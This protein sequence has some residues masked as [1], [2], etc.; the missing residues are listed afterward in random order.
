VDPICHTLAGAAIGEA[1]LK[2]RTALGMT[3]L[4][5]AANAPDIDIAVLA[6]GTLQMYFR[7]GWT[8]GVVAMVVL[9][10]LLTGLML[11]WDRWVRQRRADPPPPVDGTQVLLLA[12]IGMLS[13]PFLDYLNSYGVR[14]LKPF[15]DHWFYGDALY[16]IDPWMYVLLGGAVMLAHVSGRE[17]RPRPWI[18][19][20]GLAFAAAY[21]AVM[22]AS[23]I[24]ARHVV[25]TGLARAGR[26]DARFMVTPV[27]VNPFRREVIIDAGDRYER[28]FVWFEPTPRFRPAGFGVSKG[29][30]DPAANRAMLTPLAQQFLMWSRFPFFVVDR[31][32]GRTRV[33]LNDY[34]YSTPTGRDGW[35]GVH[36]DLD[37]LE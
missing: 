11:L 19:R 32:G 37:T 7:R 31:T 34:R 23:N 18:A 33:F 5:V 36:I 8:H 10:I 30:D 6:T 3:T 14:L 29:L 12:Y 24:W 22:L 2:H 9:P 13:H 16:I 1:G 25:E 26:A 15:S 28:G 17:G 35:A 20:L 27:L 4:L 21:I